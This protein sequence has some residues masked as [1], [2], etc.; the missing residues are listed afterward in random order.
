M[1]PKKIK[2]LF[3]RLKDA[4]TEPERV[5][6]LCEKYLSEST[7]TY[8]LSIMGATVDPYNL[9]SS[10]KD[11]EFGLPIIQELR[12]S[13]TA[14]LHDRGYR[15]NIRTHQEHTLCG[16]S[17]SGLNPNANEFP[18]TVGAIL[19]NE[20]TI[21]EA[22]GARRLK[23]LSGN[24]IGKYWGLD[25]IHCILLPEIDDEGVTTKDPVL[26]GPKGNILAER[27][28]EGAPYKR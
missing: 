11:R 14:L 12:Q 18:Y 19:N 25:G 7:P 4:T 23:Y 2:E 22:K 8:E 20:I 6:E 5:T 24:A 15:N 21:E 3:D 26:V 27:L 1:D 28:V 17:G 9:L 16:S 10:L 13:L